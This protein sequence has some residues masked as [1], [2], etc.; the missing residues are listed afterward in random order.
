MRQIRTCLAVC[1][2]LLL[3]VLVLS[4]CDAS[5]SVQASA[6]VLVSPTP[7]STEVIA[8]LE[9]QPIEGP[10]PVATEY[11]L[12]ELATPTSIPATLIGQPTLDTLR[13]LETHATRPTLPPPPDRVN[14]LLCDSFV[15]L[16]STVID[17]MREIFA[18]GQTLGR[19]PQAF[20]KAGDSTIES[21]LL[22]GKV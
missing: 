3:L 17:H 12:A 9:P 18:K 20:S 5:P 8:T 7:E 19:N 1:S 10:D 4:G 21:P 14:G 13:A 15:V 16:D 11:A 6:A 22:P 2:A